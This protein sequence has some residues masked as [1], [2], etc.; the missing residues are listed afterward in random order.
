M[1]LKINIKW[2]WRILIAI[3]IF[4]LGWFSQA[5]YEIVSAMRRAF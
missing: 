2:V 4:G 1:I 3:I 5:I